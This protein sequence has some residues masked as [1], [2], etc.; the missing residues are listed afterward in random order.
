L[1]NKLLYEFPRPEFIVGKNERVRGRYS[2]SLRQLDVTVRRNLGKK[3]PIYLFVDAKRRKRKVDVQDVEKVIGLMQD[4]NVNIGGIVATKGFTKGAQNRAKMGNIHLEIMGTEEA[5]EMNF[6]ELAREVFPMDWAFHP[7]MAKAFRAV[8]KGDAHVFIE[9]LESVPYEE[10]IQTVNTSVRVETLKPGI[11]KALRFVAQIHFDSA[12]RFNTI[13]L[14]DEL[15]ALDYD[16]I[17]TLL[18]TEKD[19]ETRELLTAL[20]GLT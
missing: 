12:W 4:V 10:W 8:E 20:G 9:A 7:Q 11:L 16:F 14:L 15:G 17:S 2:R 6:R 13:Q 19:P 3:K 5:L 18:A 1:F